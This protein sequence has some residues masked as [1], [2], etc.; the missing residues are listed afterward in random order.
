MR[1][2]L[3]L[4]VVLFTS[5]CW[6]QP[7][8]VFYVKFGGPDKEFGYDVEEIYN[9]QYIL[10]GSTSSYGSGSSDAYIILIDS[11]GSEVWN[12]V[13]GGAEADVANSVVYNPTDSGIV[14]TGFSSSKGTG[15]YDVMAMR[16]KKNGDI[17]WEKYYGTTDWEFGTDAELTS[18]GNVVICGTSSNGP[19]GKSDGLAVKINY[20]TGELIWKKNFGGVESDEFDRIKAKSNGNF[21]IGGNTRSYGDLQNDLWLFEVDNNGDSVVSAVLGSKPKA[22]HLYDFTVD[23]YQNIVICG[24]YDTSVTNS[25]KNVSYLYKVTSSFTFISDTIYDGK[26]NIEKFR[27]ITAVPNTDSYFLAR[28]IY[29]PG[30]G[31]DLQVMRIIYN[32]IFIDAKDHGDLANDE[33][34]RII[35]T[36]D[37]GLAIIG[38]RSN[39]L[40]GQEDLYFLKIDE[41]LS[42][43]PLVVG[44][45]YESLAEIKP[46]YYGRKIYLPAS[47]ELPINYTLVNTSGKIVAS[48]ATSS[49][50]IQLPVD[51]PVGLYFVTINGVQSYRFKI[52]VSESE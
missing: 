1:T 51:I 8:K 15:G 44:L 25:G 29:H 4:L 17:V 28:T 46:F 14:V 42:Y 33:G 47:T 39:E 21:I 6:C 13:V 3:S 9:R 38:Y 11:M 18:D 27:A 16:F 26:T 5:I 41:Q 37:N 52:I 35:K 50:I 10:V 12:K 32:Y 40:S 19:Y 24:S 30:N 34:I 45:D 22:E 43:A 49:L 7:P 2:L 23:N 36:S 20:D 31:M 48:T